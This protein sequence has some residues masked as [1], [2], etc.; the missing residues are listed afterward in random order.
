[1][2]VA[3]NLQHESYLMEYR[4]REQLADIDRRWQMVDWTRSQEKRP[5]LH[6]LQNNWQLLRQIRRIHIQV[7]FEVKTPCPEAIP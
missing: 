3:L 4:R 5:F 2:E 7:S 1:M 6:H